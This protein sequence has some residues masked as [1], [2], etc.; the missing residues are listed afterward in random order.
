MTM[1]MEQPPF[2]VWLHSAVSMTWLAGGFGSRKEAIDAVRS[3][4]VDRGDGNP[5]WSVHSC[6]RIN[7]QRPC[8]D[9]CGCD[10]ESA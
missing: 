6:P 8:P 9:S 4:E 2:S 10:K 3:G 5:T 1:Q 7:L